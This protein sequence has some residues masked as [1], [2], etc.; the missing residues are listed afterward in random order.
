MS[1]KIEFG[2]MFKRMVN[3]NIEPDPQRVAR[4]LESILCQMASPP[5]GLPGHD[6]PRPDSAPERNDLPDRR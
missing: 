1:E 6:P 5:D 3:K 4:T 2:E